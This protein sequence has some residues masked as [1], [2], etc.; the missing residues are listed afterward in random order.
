VLSQ[1]G[2]RVAASEQEPCLKDELSAAS[3]GSFD[4]RILRA[5]RNPSQVPVKRC[6]SARRPDGSVCLQRLGAH[7][8]R[9]RGAALLATPLLLPAYTGLISG[10]TF[11]ASKLPLLR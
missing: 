9:A 5:L 10:T 7:Q 11:E 8:L 4:A 6:K 2:S 1:P 3:S